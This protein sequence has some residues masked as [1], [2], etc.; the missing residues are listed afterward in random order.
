MYLSIAI[1][2]FATALMAHD[3]TIMA[4]ARMHNVGSTFVIGLVLF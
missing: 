2:L 4:Q 3:A 1:M